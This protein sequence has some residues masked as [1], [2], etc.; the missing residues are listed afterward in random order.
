[1]G[2]QLADNPSE[3]RCRVSGVDGRYG[4]RPHIAVDIRILESQSM[5]CDPD[6]GNEP[7][8][9]MHVEQLRGYL[10]R[11]D[12][13]VEGLVPVV[14]QIKRDGLLAGDGPD[15]DTGQLSLQDAEIC[16]AP[17]IVRIVGKAAFI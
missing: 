3:K 11:R 14:R 5:L 8:V 13:R 16:G 7:E 4:H 9:D 15:V 17:R 12:V 10:L 2:G 1:M 6:G